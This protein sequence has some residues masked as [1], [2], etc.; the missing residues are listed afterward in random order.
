MIVFCGVEGF[1]AG[2]WTADLAS[3]FAERVGADLRLMDADPAQQH[4][5]AAYQAGEEPLIFGHAPT[6]N[7]AATLRAAPCPVVVAPGGVAREDWGEVI[8]G[9]LAARNSEAAAETAG[10]LAARLNLPLR[11]V[12]VQERLTPKQW[13]PQDELRK[14]HSAATHAADSYLSTRADL[15]HGQPAATL[16]AAAAERGG[17]VVVA[18]DPRA[19]WFNLRPWVTTEL[20]HGSRDMIVVVPPSSPGRSK[21]GRSRATAHS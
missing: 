13:Q 1:A 12:A 15:R 20:I 16:R 6:R 14:L 19:T 3:R 9:C 8:L 4:V 11:L 10:A 21:I 18:A 7:V 5:R 17:L 2:P